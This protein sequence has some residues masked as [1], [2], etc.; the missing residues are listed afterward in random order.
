MSVATNPEDSRRIALAMNRADL[1]AVE[2]LDFADAATRAGTWAD[3]PQW[4]RNIVAETEREH[5]PA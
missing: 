4:V 2:R 3:L 5:G 1:T